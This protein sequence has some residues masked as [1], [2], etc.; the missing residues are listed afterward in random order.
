MYA[1]RS[2]YELVILLRPQVVENAQ[3]WDRELD[4]ITSY[5][6]CYT[7]LLR[8]VTLMSLHSSK[9]LEY[10]V[11][12]LVGL[13]EEYLPHKKSIHETFDVDEE[14][15]LCYVGITRNNFV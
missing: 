12:F 15:R 1:I 8:A 5:N 2:Y 11:V 7:K 13:E 3:S 14:R 9:G 6:V 4:R 10:P